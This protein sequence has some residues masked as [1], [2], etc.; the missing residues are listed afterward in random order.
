MIEI[1]R[2]FL[3]KPGYEW[4]PESK[5]TS[6]K[7]GYLSVDH[8]CVIRVRIAGENAFLTI[9]GKVSGIS[10]IEFE[11]EIPKS[12]AEDLMKMCLNSVVEK[13]R[14]KIPTGNL[15]WEVDVFEGANRGLVIAEIEL[16]HEEQ[17]L[18]KPEWIG[19]EVSFDKRYF[20]SYL[21]QNPYSEW[22]KT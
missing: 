16:Q 11:Y 9:K 3:L 4:H 21:S 12:E 13:T 7:Q 8:E 2:K 22:M 1:E 14:Y 20:N 6:I 19:R 17:E 10:R 5:G 18:T 15:V